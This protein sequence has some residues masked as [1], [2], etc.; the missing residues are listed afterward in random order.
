LIGPAHAWSAQVCS[1]RPVYFFLIYLF[2][3]I[4]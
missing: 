2:N 3:Q 4:C 1:D